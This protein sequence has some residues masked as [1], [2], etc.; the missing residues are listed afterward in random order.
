MMASYAPIMQ[1]S[2][3]IA[4][5]FA[6][7]KSDDATPATR[8]REQMKEWMRFLQQQEHPSHVKHC[9]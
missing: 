9:S 8:Q 5:S 2:Q 1:M 7:A 4:M 3:A 6:K